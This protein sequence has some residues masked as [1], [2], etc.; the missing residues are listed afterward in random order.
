[1][2]FITYQGEGRTVPAEPDTT[3]LDAAR[4]AGIPHFHACGGHARCSTCRVLVV[5]GGASLTPRTEGERAIA[6]RLGFPADVRLACQ[7]RARGDVTVRRLVVDEEDRS[8]AL[9][10]L[11]G[12]GQRSVGEERRLAIL[13]ADLRNFTAL[14]ER[15][16]AYDV[17]H[18]LNRYF[19]RVGAVVNAHRGQIDNYMGD[20][21]M[22]LFGLAR[23]ESAVEDAVDAGLEIIAAVH[24]MRPY[25]EAQFQ[26]S[27]RAGVGIHYGDVVLGAVGAGERRRL[28]A[29]GDA[30]NLASRIEGANKEAG[31][32]VLISEAAWEVVKDK[33]EVGRRVEMGIKGKTGVY[34]LYEVVGR[35]G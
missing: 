33:V 2:P 3:L 35:R 13:F 1:M 17:I 21:V 8:L 18:L 22:A 32:E 11:R 27:L 9:E 23:P 30:V 19:N 10:D 7:A 6:A 25:V 5:E 29:I 31:T 12:D 28:T 24:A 34:A 20:G 14:S 4:R 16:V 15:L 26:A